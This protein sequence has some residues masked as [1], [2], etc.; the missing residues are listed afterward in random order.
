MLITKTKTEGKPK[1]E[2]IF[3]HLGIFFQKYPVQGIDNQIFS[4]FLVNE[5][6]S[7]A[8]QGFFRDEMKLLWNA[9]SSLSSN[10]QI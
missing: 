7:E 2:G 6:F 9:I 8:E 5:I 1:R 4:R 3:P 10:N